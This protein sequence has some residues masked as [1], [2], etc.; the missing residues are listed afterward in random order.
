M[1]PIIICEDSKKQLAQIET[2]INNYVMFHSNQF[3]VE[4]LSSDP[5]AIIQHIKEHQIQHG[6]YLLDIDLN[7]N[8]NG[9]D[10]AEWV[11]HYDT[12][13][14]IIFVTI[15][16]ELA[17]LSIQRRLEAFDF[18]DK[19]E[20]IEAF[21]DTLYE[22]LNAVYQRV[23]SPSEDNTTLT[24]SMG[25]ELYRIPIE[26]IQI[27]E[28]GAMSH[29]LKLRTARSEYNFAGKLSDYELR[30]PKLFRISK[31]VLVNPDHVIKINT[32]E[33]IIT[34]KNYESVRYSIRLS[35]AVRAKFFNEEQTY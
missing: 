32:Q 30:F 11:R 1:L 22:T 28:T 13:A 14:K 4:M 33:R 21:R 3:K 2:L 27:L 6:V 9:L 16:S 8:M 7:H 19:C 26:E 15:R 20:D 12:T 35:K 5:E 18:I 10:L 17:T 24:F 34:M 23:F 31:S 25:F 29:K